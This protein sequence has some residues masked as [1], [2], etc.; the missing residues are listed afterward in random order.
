MGGGFQIAL[1]FG[2]VRPE[3]DILGYFI[4]SQPVSGLENVD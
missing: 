1:V 4:N 2:L 3:C